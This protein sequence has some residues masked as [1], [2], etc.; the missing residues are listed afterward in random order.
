MSKQWLQMEWSLA[1]RAI[2]GGGLY[3]RGDWGRSRPRRR[4]PQRLLLRN[5]FHRAVPQ[6]PLVKPIKSALYNRNVR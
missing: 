5:P 4:S 3:H 6:R 2:H 1:A